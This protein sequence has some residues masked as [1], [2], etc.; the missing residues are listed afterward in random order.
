VAQILTEQV[1]LQLLGVGEIAVVAEDNTERRIDVERLRPRQRK[2]RSPPWDNVHGRS[3]CYPADT[4]VAGAE[5]ISHQAVGLV[6][7]EGITLAGDYPR[8]ILTTCCRT[9]RHHRAAG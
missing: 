6:H 1:F 9:C 3:P 7:V 8:R 2:K 5:H 4:H